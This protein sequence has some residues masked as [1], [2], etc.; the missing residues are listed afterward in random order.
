[1]LFNE[2]DEA[3]M[4]IAL[5]EA[6]VAASE[7]EIPVGA[8]LAKDGEILARTHNLCETRGLA[9]EH[10]EMLAIRAASEKIG[11]WRLSGCTLYVTLEPCPMCAGCAIHARVDRI[12]Y[13]A[14]DPRAGACGSVINLPSYPLEAKPNCEEGLYAEESL[15]LLRDFFA[16]KRKKFS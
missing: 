7:G 1:M 3:C 6:A 10:A 16:K 11:S 5:K 9:S 13:G 8:V 12:V 2:F 15:A 4:R 14:K